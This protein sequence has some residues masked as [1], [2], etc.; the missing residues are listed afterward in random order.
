MIYF[1]PY[2]T[3]ALSMYGV[4]KMG[5]FVW[6]TSIIMFVIIP[7]VEILMRN[8]KFNPALHKSRWGD[9]SLAL[10]PVALTAYLIMALYQSQFVTTNS[11]FFG[12]ALST[13][14]LTGAF[15]ITAAHELV[16]RRQKFFRALGVWNLVLSNFAHWGVEHVYGHHKYAAT[17]IDPGTARKNE[18][19]YAFWLR[20]YFG[21]LKG[22]YHISKQK[23]L[24][25][26]FG[27]L[28]LSVTIYFTLGLKTLALW[29]LSSIIAN[30]LLHSVDYIEH[31]G[32]LR[33][34]NEDGH[35]AAFKSHHAWDTASVATNVH[36]YNLGLHSHHHM[37]ASVPFQDLSEQPACKNMPY[38]YSVMFLLAFVPFI[39]IPMMNKRLS[40]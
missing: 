8:K 3:I 10:T 5:S 1:F 28:A 6:I 27:S 15:G 38:G 26:W 17:E 13:G 31:Y 11:E 18:W 2:L 23:V 24:M 40:A 39:Y 14:V 35:Y 29:W 30:L 34:K 36:L 32:L 19:L 4:Y 25:Y 37:K 16:H 12:L 22:A 9:I 33:P 21:V 20:T 7:I